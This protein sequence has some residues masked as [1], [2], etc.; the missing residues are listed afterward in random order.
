MVWQSALFRNHSAQPVGRGELNEHFRNIC[1]NLRPVAEI[2]FLVYL[3]V[4]TIELLQDVCMYACCCF[5]RVPLF[6][7]L[8]TV[9]H[10]AP[11][12]M[13]SSRYWSVFLQ[14]ACPTWGSTYTSSVSRIGRHV[15]YHQC[16]LGSLAYRINFV[17]FLLHFKECMIETSLLP[18]AYAM[19]F[20]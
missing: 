16:H 18:L 7:T 3:V 9:T 20:T 17:N 1:K 12:F 4:R 8:W 15:L 10:Q 14:G 19:T 6:A 5:S 11:L 13:E 2:I